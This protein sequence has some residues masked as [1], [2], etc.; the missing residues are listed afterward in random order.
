VVQTVIEPAEVTPIFQVALLATGASCRLTLRG[1]LCQASVAA[2]QA[3]VDQLGGLPCEEVVVDLTS[4][5]G[6]DGVGANVLLGLYHYVIAR[7]GVFRVTEAC[8]DVAET[9][10]SVVGA[11]IPVGD[12]IS[13]VPL[14]L[15][16]PST[17][18][19]VP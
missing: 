17:S 11:L 3:Q 7:G 9:L 15:T 5:S 12:L 16:A 10:H 4:L 13:G 2:L 19:N 14:V 8:Q 6:L 1:N 18:S